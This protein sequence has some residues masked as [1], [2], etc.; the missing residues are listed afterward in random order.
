MVKV[1]ST[2]ILLFGYACLGF[3]F[4]YLS[5]L[6]GVKDLGGNRSLASLYVL[7]FSLI[8]FFGLFKLPE[9]FT[10]ISAL[11]FLGGLMLVGYINIKCLPDLSA[12]LLSVFCLGLVGFV[13]S[14]KANRVAKAYNKRLNNGQNS[15]G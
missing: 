6:N 13:I 11:N 12:F 8:M 7:I 10:I 2:K 4:L 9:Y 3:I 5:I 1:S 14:I 15:V